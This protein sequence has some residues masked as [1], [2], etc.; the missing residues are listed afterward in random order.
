MLGER[1]HLKLAAAASLGAR[2]RRWPAILT[3]TPDAP[4]TVCRCTVPSSPTSPPIAASR[5]P[6]PSTIN[7]PSPFTPG[8]PRSNN[9]PSNFSVLTRIVPSNCPRARDKQTRVQWAIDSARRK[10]GLADALQP[11]YP[12]L[13]PEQKRRMAALRTAVSSLRTRT[14][15]NHRPNLLNIAG[16]APIRLAITVIPELDHPRFCGS[17]RAERRRCS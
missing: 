9:A 2:Q 7:T 16:R 4:R 11:L 13:S 3:P 10:F 15:G 8:Q 6:P 1:I 17:R 12:T 5:P 14:K